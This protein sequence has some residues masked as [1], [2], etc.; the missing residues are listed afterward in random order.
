MQEGRP[1]LKVICTSDLHKSEHDSL[2]AAPD[3]HPKEQPMVT[4]FMRPTRVEKLAVSSNCAKKLT[5]AV[6]EFIARDL[7]PISFVDGTGFLNLMQ[8]AEPWYIVPCHATITARI[9]S[10]YAGCKE[11]LLAVL[12]AQSHVSLTTD[13][14]T[15]RAGD[16]YISLTMSLC[17]F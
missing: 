7:R 9:Q 10:M 3:T 13:M 11:K 14:W 15:S 6:A 2:F 16:G 5:T 17:V 12:A 1:T 8:I 4:D